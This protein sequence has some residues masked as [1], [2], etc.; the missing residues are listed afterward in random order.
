MSYAIYLKRSVEKELDH[1]PSDIYKKIIHKIISLKDNPISRGFKKLTGKDGYR[2]R[3]RDYRILYTI[4]DEDK[5]IE[6]YS[7]AHRK[8]VYR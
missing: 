4:N 3:V 1:L 7:V 6:V 5:R 8:E 2:L